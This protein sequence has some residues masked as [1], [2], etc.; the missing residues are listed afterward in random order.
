[1]SE[2]L[3][4]IRRLQDAEATLQDAWDTGNIAGALTWAR[5]EFRDIRAAM[6]AEVDRCEAAYAKETRCSARF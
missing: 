2:L 6:Q 1:M 4:Y 3:A 5:R